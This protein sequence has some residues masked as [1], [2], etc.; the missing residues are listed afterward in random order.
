M[1]SDGDSDKQ[2]NPL[3]YLYEEVQCL[4]SLEVPRNPG[5]GLKSCTQSGGRMNLWNLWFG[6]KLEGG[7]HIL[8]FSWNG[9]R[10]WFWIWIIRLQPCFF[11]YQMIHTIQFVLGVVSNTASYLR[12]WAL[13]V[14]LYFIYIYFVFGEMYHIWLKEGFSE[15]KTWYGMFCRLAHLKISVVFNEKFFQSARGDYNT[16]FSLLPFFACWSAPTMSQG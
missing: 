6:P 1:T 11:F 9:T 3:L 14:L 12:L 10:L 15:H 2:N 13:G 8:V 7:S 16:C 5:R 4:I